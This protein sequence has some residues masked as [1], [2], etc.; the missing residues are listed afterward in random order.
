MT[1]QGTVPHPPAG[2]E[3][4]L[5]LDD[6]AAVA[7]Q[8]MP[9]A[10]FEYVDSGAGDEHTMRWNRERWSEIKLKPRVLTD[11]S[12]IFT[13][14]SFLGQHF[15]VPILLAPTAYQRLYHPEG[16]L[17]TIAGA[18]AAGVSLVLA[19]FASHSVEDIAKQ[20]RRRF[21]FQLYVQRDRELT[22]SVVQR[23]EAAGCATLC[24]TVDTPILGIR[25][26]EMRSQ[27]AVPDD[28]PMPNMIGSPTDELSRSHLPEFGSIY[29]RRLDPRL[30]WDDIS[31]LRSIAKV[32]ILLKGILNP[33]D[34]RR[35]LD[36]GASGIIV[37]NHGGRNL[38]TLPATAE[39]LPR[40]VEAVAGR[41]PVL[42]DGGIR[43]GTDVLKALAL[44]A[45]AVM[46]GRPYVYG[47]AVAGAAGV[48]RVLQILKTELMMAMALAGVCSIK[49]IDR[50]VIWE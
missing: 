41:I 35:A 7:K 37:S 16:E 2:L 28:M 26:R 23:V 46:I 33:E 22:R 32:P 21:W 48:E 11:V 10:T 6:F 34:A 38:D 50:Q 47:L 25:T 20:V 15:H 4:F 8:R 31:W 5:S 18:N 3:E 39:A 17:A 19:S 27:F 44:G 45:K 29:S 12:Q 49:E 1:S 40:V 30:T 42:V 36:A 43:R 14:T 9:N 13:E 24:V